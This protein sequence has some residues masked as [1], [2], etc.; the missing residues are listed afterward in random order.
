MRAPS[1]SAGY[2]RNKQRPPATAAKSR[3]WPAFGKLLA[4]SAIALFSLALGLFQ[5]LRAGGLHALLEYDDGVWFGS[6]L[7]MVDG[8]IPYRDF[9]LD[10]PPLV[11]LLLSPVALLSHAI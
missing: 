4:V 3:G 10:Q 5:L 7:R 11:P 8:A 1:S 9:V 2:S 6:T